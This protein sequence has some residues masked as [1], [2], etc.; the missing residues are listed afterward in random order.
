VCKPWTSPRKSRRPPS[1]SKCALTGVRSCNVRGMCGRVCLQEQA[2]VY[3]YTRTHVDREIVGLP[4]SPHL[5]HTS[6]VACIRSRM[7]PPR[8]YISSVPRPSP[9]VEIHRDTNHLTCQVL[10]ARGTSRRSGIRRRCTVQ[11]AVRLRSQC[12]DTDT[13]G[14]APGIPRVGQASFCPRNLRGKIVI[15]SWPLV[16]T[17]PELQHVCLP[18]RLAV[19]LPKAMPACHVVHIIAAR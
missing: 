18:V 2:N 4:P 19:S 12:H 15:L 5:P 1:A 6:F 8:V 9:Q 14:F 17:P 13:G 7:S 3:T 11:M 16:C 10:Y